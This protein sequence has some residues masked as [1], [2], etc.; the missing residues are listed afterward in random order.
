LVQNLLPSCLLLKKV[1]IKIYKTIILPMVLYGCETWC[2]IL[3]EGHRQRVFENRVLWRIFGPR[4]YEVTEKWRNLHNKD[5]HDLYSAPSIVR[6]IKSGRMRWVG[7][8]TQMGEKRSAYRLLT[9]SQRP[10]KTTR[11][12]KA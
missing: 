2:L 3:R 11:K 9:E 1:K 4:R 5:L 8:V 12:A 7:H 6:I 10:R